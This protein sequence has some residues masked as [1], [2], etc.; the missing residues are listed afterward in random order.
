MKAKNVSFI[1]KHTEKLVLLVGVGFLIAVIVLYVLGGSVTVKVK[2][3]AVAADEVED[4]ITRKAD[5]LKRKL[6][7]SSELQA[8][9]TPDVESRFVAAL[10]RSATPEG[11]VE[12]TGVAFAALNDLSGLPI[13]T[14]GEDVPDGLTPYRVVTVPAPF[15]MRARAGQGTLS[16]VAVAGSSDLLRIVGNRAP[17]D[18]TWVAVGG[19]FPIDQIAKQLAEASD[20]DVLAVPEQWWKNGMEMVDI[21]L[22]RQE[23]TP[24]GWSEPAKVS[25]MPGSALASYRKLLS[26]R[27]VTPDNI[28]SLNESL[29][30][31]RVPLLRPNFYELKGGSWSPPSIPG[32]EINEA[33]DGGQVSPALRELADELQ[34]IVALLEAELAA[35]DK[36][37]QEGKQ[38]RPVQLRKIENLQ[39][40]L[41]EVQ[42]KI[43]AEEQKSGATIIAD[44]G[45][46][47]AAPARGGFFRDDLDAI[48]QPVRPDTDGD[49][50]KKIVRL[51][52][53][54]EPIFWANDLGVQ[55]GMTYRYKARLVFTNPLFGQRLPKAQADEAARPMT[56]G[57][58]SDWTE[59]VTTPR[60]LYQFLMSRNSN[61][62]TGTVEVW[63]F[64]DGEWWTE[65]FTVAAGDVIG[66]IGSNPRRL[67]RQVDIAPDAEAAGPPRIDFNT[68]LIA[69]ALDTGYLI[70]TTGQMETSRL[71]ALDGDE[72]VN[73]VMENDRQRHTA[74]RA[75]LTK[76]VLKFNPNLLNRR[77]GG[78]DGGPGFEPD[79]GPEGG[80]EIW[81]DEFGDPVRP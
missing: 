4:I 45:D 66:G 25:A 81:L 70:S 28:A 52:V 48:L 10:R 30:T 18:M 36:L 23:K 68:G 54:T 61:G 17:Y 26:T 40:E 80:E 21:E 13:A 29:R 58:W 38:L 16:D 62:E 79:F 74:L 63:K 19:R 41:R 75:E 46:P 72:L 20:R 24:A 67:Q 9:S 50:A 3:Q 76:P 7:G 64:N 31:N 37:V 34:R 44:K 71:L 49:I 35:A 53:N 6:D 55:P 69:V 78:P 27:D 12:G 77:P 47:T 14:A 22:W 56:I 57:A 39:D 2:G 51:W 65:T 1:D 60:R 11:S 33:D 5:E 8:I 43:A 32:L 15:D 73:L 42:T 59:P